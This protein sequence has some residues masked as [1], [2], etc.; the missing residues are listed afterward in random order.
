MGRS[1]P[2]SG[3]EESRSLRTTE[4]E[5]QYDLLTA[6]LLGV[7]V[8]AA[9]ALLVSAAMPRREVHPVRRALRQGSRIAVRGGRAAMAAPEAVREQLGEYLSTAREAIADTVESELKDLRRAIRRR[10][11]RLGL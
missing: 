6:A 4:R 2:A 3:G 1:T 7:A 9:A 5:E 11:R 8:G 10:R